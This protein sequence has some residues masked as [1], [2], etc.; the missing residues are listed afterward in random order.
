MNKETLFTKI[1]EGKIPSYK[2]YEDE[3]TYAFL[4]IHP[5]QPGHTLVVP[6][7][8][9]ENLWDLPD[10]DFQAVLSTCKRLA[11]RLRN[12]LKTE[13]IGLEVIGVDVPHAHVHLV[14]FNTTE[15]FRNIPDKE[16]EPDYKALE[17]IAKKIIH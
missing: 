17:E 2:I 1:I 11:I 5:I 15:E 6:K 14:P 7:L 12:T 13:R 16:A 3:L 8:P 9:V 10:K 4:D